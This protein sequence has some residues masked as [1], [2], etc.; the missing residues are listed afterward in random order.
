MKHGKRDDFNQGLERGLRR[1][2]D[3][4]KYFIKEIAVVT[5]LQKCKGARNG[6]TSLEG[7]GQCVLLTLIYEH[8]KQET[9]PLLCQTQ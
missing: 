9:P 6:N 2:P 8:C 7:E 5:V 1:R 4:K 3:I